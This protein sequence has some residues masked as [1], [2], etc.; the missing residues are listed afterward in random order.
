MDQNKLGMCQERAKCRFLN[1]HF[2]FGLS[3]PN[4]STCTYNWNRLGSKCLSGANLAD[5]ASGFFFQSSI[6]WTVWCHVIQAEHKPQLLICSP[7]SMFKW[8][9]LPLIKDDFLHTWLPNPGFWLVMVSPSSTCNERSVAAHFVH[10][11]RK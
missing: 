3:L 7:L 6:T 8:L 2:A 10:R 5:L 9:A 11:A 1:A 4:T